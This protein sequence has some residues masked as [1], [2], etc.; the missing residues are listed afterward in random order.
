MMWSLVALKTIVIKE[1]RRFLRIWI[2]TLLPSA[3]NM[4][5]YFIIFGYLMGGRIGQMNG[6]DYMQFIVPGLIMMSVITNSYTNV[7]FSFFSQKFQRSIE[8]LIIAPVGHWVILFG[9]VAGGITRG[10]LV[11][12][13]VLATALVFTDIQIANWWLTLCVLFLTALLFSV[14]GFINALFAKKF[15]DVSIVPTFVLTPLTYLGGV[16]YSIHL[17]PQVWQNIS[18]LNP[19]IYMVNAFRAGMMGYS[20]VNLSLSLGLILVMNV[21]VVFYALHLLKVGKGI[22]S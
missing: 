1:V 20:E 22:R 2:Q 4:A 6:I 3:I 21:F 13:I 18:L 10:V 16:F 19:I 14:L 11:G 5:L 12:L 17:L 8:E 15:D 7:V 9:Y